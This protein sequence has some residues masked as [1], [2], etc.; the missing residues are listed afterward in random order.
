MANGRWSLRWALL[1]VLAAL[2]GL[3]SLERAWPQDAADAPG[4]DAVAVVD[5]PSASSDEAIP[6]NLFDIIKMGGVVM[7]P[8][9]FCS[10]L[11][12]CFAF[13][14][15]ISLRRGR[16]APGPFVKRFLHQLRDGQLDRETALELCEKNDSVV[17][18]VF[19]GAVR[20]W[21]RPSV[22]VEQAFL[23]AGERAGNGLRRYLRLFHAVSTICPLL[24]LLGT[25]FGVIRAFNSIATIDEASRS[26][27]LA[28]GIAE[29]LLA[30]AAGL[31]V[32]IVALICYWIFAAR[33]DQLVLDIDALGQEVV[34]F[35]SAEG[36]AESSQGRLARTR[37]RE[38]AAA[39][40][41]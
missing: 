11:T 13:E 2:M 22:E 20:K 28:K 33:A 36:L 40:P 41:A 12:V 4:A 18:R 37:K 23:D 26:Q 38:A 9:L 5:E 17:A 8:I 14:R 39:K 3:G 31:S 24:G 25:V 32:A 21:G 35:T 16:V 19:A 34:Q 15:L 7:Y 30:T 6:M 27:L 29:A 1:I 10:V